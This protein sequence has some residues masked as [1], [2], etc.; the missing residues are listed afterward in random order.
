MVFNTT[1]KITSVYVVALKKKKTILASNK[2]Q[3]IYFYHTEF[4]YKRTSLAFICMKATIEVFHLSLNHFIQKSL[5]T[6]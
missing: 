1:F 4:S 2:G 6:C 5:T 3:F